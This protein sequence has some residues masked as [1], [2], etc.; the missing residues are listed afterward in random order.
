M[1][2]VP[3]PAEV[4]GRALHRLNTIALLI[5]W[6]PWK[7]RLYME[8]VQSSVVAAD[9]IAARSEAEWFAYVGHVGA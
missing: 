5:E 3:N 2:T 7:Y 1:P 4:H 8:R 6:A 9:E